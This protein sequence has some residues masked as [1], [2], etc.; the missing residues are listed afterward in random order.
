MNR[1]MMLQPILASGCRR[2]V[3][4]RDLQDGSEQDDHQRIGQGVDDIDDAHDD[5]VDL[6]AE[7][8]CDGADRHADDQHDKA[9]EEADGQEMRVP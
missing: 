3:A 8:A 6:A 2:L 1:L 9:R 4:D 5:E 7:I